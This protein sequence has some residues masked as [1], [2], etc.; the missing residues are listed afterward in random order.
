M[1]GSACVPRGREIASEADLREIFENTTVQALTA[2]ASHLMPRPHLHSLRRVG[3]KR[4]LTSIQEANA[5]RLASAA[6]RRN[7][8]KA[9]VKWRSN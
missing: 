2:F 9:S 6:T 5:G 8:K 1:E 3:F 7:E 4:A